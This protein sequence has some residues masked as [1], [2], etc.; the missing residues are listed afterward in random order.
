MNDYSHI[1]A[2]LNIKECFTAVADISDK[3][4]IAQAGLFPPG[5]KFSES[6]SSVFVVCN[7]ANRRIREV[8]WVAHRIR[9]RNH[10]CVG[11]RRA[12]A[13]WENTIGEQCDQL[14]VDNPL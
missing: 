12:F 3:K 1:R 5:A 6:N 2:N 7:C 9:S 11:R 14:I 4:T 10:L 8:Y 13:K